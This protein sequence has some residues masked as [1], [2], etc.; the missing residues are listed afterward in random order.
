MRPISRQAH[1]S[2]AMRVGGIPGIRWRRLPG[3]ILTAGS[4][5]ILAAAVM[6]DSRVFTT[7]DPRVRLEAI[8]A[9]PWG[10]TAQAIAFP[11][12]FAAVA[13]GALLAGRI[14]IPARHPARRVA[15]L[16]GWLAVAAVVLWLPISAA[17]LEAGSAA[18]TL[19]SSAGP[20]EW[21]RAF[22]TPTFAAYTVAALLSTAAAAGAAGWSG[23]RRR[24][25]IAIATLAG[26]GLVAYPVLGDWPPFATYLLVLAL[27]VSL[28]TGTEP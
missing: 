15:G 11:I 9:R 6:P 13:C 4:V 14:L 17:R 1:L 2:V 5:L 22:D 28:S 10:W 20:S 26:G 8:A 16:G 23:L 21:R 18:H 25:G 24:S 7:A 12:G 27:G 3:V 19:L